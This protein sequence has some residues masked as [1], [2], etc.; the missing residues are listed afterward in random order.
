[1]WWTDGSTV[2]QLWYFIT[3]MFFAV[4]DEQVVLLYFSCCGEQLILLYFIC[5]ILQHQVV[6]RWWYCPSIVVFYNTNV[7][8][9]VQWTGYGNVL[10][11]WYFTTPVFLQYVVNRWWCCT[12]VVVFFNTNVFFSICNT[13]LMVLLSL[14]WWNQSPVYGHCVVKV[15]S[16][17]VRFFE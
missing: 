9:C 7:F 5:G 14:H 2:P 17:V 12:L 13:Y 3:P 15:K 8:W 1:M 16:P 10:H 6:N 4:C 11:L